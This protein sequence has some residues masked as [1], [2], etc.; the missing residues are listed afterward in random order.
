[1]PHRTKDAILDAATRLFAVRGYEG[2]S[3]REILRTAGANTAAAHYHFG[4]KEAVFVACMERWL[5]PLMAERA[6]A[7][8]TLRFE[9]KSRKER[10]EALI[11]AYVTPHLMLCREPAAHDYMRLM[12]NYARAPESAARRLFDTVIEPVRGRYLNALGE[13]APEVEA[14]D[15]RRL[16]TAIIGMMVSLPW[17]RTYESVAGRSAM[18]SDPEQ[19]IRVVTAMGS[20]GIMELI[21]QSQSDSPQKSADAGEANVA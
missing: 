17:D 7:F 5:R 2:A 13:A 3:L 15:L 14:D 6:R 9:R 18:P 1:M 11:R 19:L 4:S 12:T 16:F 10:I 8:D 20:A 21:A